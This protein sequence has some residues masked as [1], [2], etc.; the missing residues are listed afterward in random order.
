MIYILFSYFYHTN[1]INMNKTVELVQEWVAF[2]A[3]HP[4]GTLEDFCQYYLSRKKAGSHLSQEESCPPTYRL[5]YPLTK[6]INRLSKLWMFFTM[7]AM[8]PLGIS[9]F[10]EFVFLYTVNQVASIRKKD[11]IYQHFLEISS[12]LLVIKRLVDKEFLQEKT[13]EQDKRSKQVSLTPKGKHTLEACHVALSKVAENLYGQMPDQEMEQCIQYL[14]P[15]EKS[16][17]QQWNQIKN[18]DPVV[19]AQS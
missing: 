1:A 2:E 18:F 6:V 8:K 17:A 10:D 16:I 3:D 13:D 11:L 5:I 15:R 14:L 12:G 7:D 9:S 19:N 4:E